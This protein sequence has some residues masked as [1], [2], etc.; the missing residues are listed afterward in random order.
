MPVASSKRAWVVVFLLFTFMLINFVDKTV[1]GLAGVPIMQELGLTPSQFGLVGSSFFF[2]FSISAVVTGFIV[3]RVQTRWVLAIMGLV[4]A[5]TQFP[6]V[7]TVGLTTLMVCRIALGAGEGPAYPVALHSAYK[8]FPNEQRTLPTALISQG[9][10]VGVLLALPALNWVIVHY[11]WHWAFG[12]LGIIGL[13]WTL[14]WLLFGRE[15]SIA[16]ASDA[17][18]GLHADVSYR[19]LL[20]CPTIIASWCAFFGAYWGLSLAIS[21]QTPYLVNVLGFSQQEVGL[22]SALPWGFGVILVISLGWY[23]QRLLTRGVSSRV[24]RGILGGACVALGGVVLLL[25]PYMPNATMRILATMV[26]TSLPAVIYVFSH[27]I[28]GEITPVS[29]R[30]AMLAIGNAVGTSAGILAPYIMG[31]VI[32]R[33]ATPTDGYNTGYEICGLIMLVGGIIGMLFMRPEKDGAR[34]AR[35]DTLRPAAAE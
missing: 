10:G 7:G 15:G 28:V 13:M 1:I 22:L 5:L 25:L 2:L 17:F 18:K 32:E 21:W 35:A 3:N 24:A 19:D 29:Q 31:N 20:A 9:A 8:W 4:W 6:M 33:A 16:E 34:L 12:I 30:G 14:A 23:S 27:A 26:G 11:S